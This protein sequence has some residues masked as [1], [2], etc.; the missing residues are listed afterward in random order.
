MTAA[1]CQVVRLVGDEGDPPITVMPDPDFSDGFVCVFADGPDAVKHWGPVRIGSL[2][3]DVAR[4]LGHALIACA[5][6]VG[7]T[8]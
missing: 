7:A 4:A 5:D 2:P 1:F 8:R 3:A 6:E